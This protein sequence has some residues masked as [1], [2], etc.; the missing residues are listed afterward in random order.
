MPFSLVSRV[1]KN[2]SF[3]SACSVAI[4]DSPLIASGLRGSNFPMFCLRHLWDADRFTASVPKPFRGSR[5]PTSGL[6]PARGEPGGRDPHQLGNPPILA[7][8]EPGWGHD[9][10][11]F[12]GH[13]PQFGN[14]LLVSFLSILFPLFCG[15]HNLFFFP[16]VTTVDFPNFFFFFAALRKNAI[17]DY[18]S[19]V[20]HVPT[21]H[22]LFDE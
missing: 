4:G 7:T 20:D 18:R 2:S 6:P 13:D 11:P 1:V 10:G 17:L 5:P 22:E 12:W 9:P 19:D 3:A 14:S 15:D 21:D 16:T 8:G